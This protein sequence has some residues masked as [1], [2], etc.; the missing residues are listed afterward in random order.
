MNLT[1]PPPALFL[2]INLL[3]AVPWDSDPPISGT[4]GSSSQFTLVAPCVLGL[5][6]APTYTLSVV[7]ADGSA[8]HVVGQTSGLL[9][10]CLFQAQV[11]I[12]VTT[13]LALSNQRLR[14]TIA[15]LVSLHLQLGPDTYL[16]ATDFVPASGH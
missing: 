11:P 9:G 4:F 15:T 14:L 2:G 10:L 12:P 16:Q 1:P 8:A 13:P 7:N 6:V 3:G 5:T